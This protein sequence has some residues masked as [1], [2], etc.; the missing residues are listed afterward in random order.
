MANFS[1]KTVTSNYS[2]TPQD[3]LIKVIAPAATVSIG[4]PAISSVNE[5]DSFTVLDAGQ[6]AATYNII[7]ASTDGTL[8]NGSVTSVTCNVNG[9][10]V[11]AQKVSGSWSVINDVNAL[12]GPASSTANTLPRFSGTSGKVMLSSGIVVTDTN[13]MSGQ[14]DVVSS[15]ANTTY[16]L[17][18][19][20]TGKIIEMNSSVSRVLTLPATFTQGFNCSVVQAGVAAGKVV[21]TAASGATLTG[22]SA[23]TTSAGVWARCFL[24][25]S[26][27]TSGTNAVWV[28][29]GT[30]G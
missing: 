24:Y 27:N 23:V 14:L 1:V 28:L 17:V 8:I 9:G 4:L 7:V 6:T 3:S 15:N 22:N 20:D 30:V 19:G 12:Q 18:A 26:S 10:S 29:S 5:G 11:V 2:I 25:V 13:A 21:F 16:T